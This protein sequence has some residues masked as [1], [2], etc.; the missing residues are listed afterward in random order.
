MKLNQENIN[1]FSISEE[2]WHAI[3]HGLGLA[4]SIAGLAILVGF[5]SINGSPIVIISSAIYGT[6]LI[7]MYGSSTLYHAITHR[8][9]KGLFQK[10]DHSSIYFLI[11][12]SYTPITLISLEGVWG[13]SLAT[14]VWSTAAFGIYMKF[15][16][17]NRFET[18]SL[19]LYVLMGWSIVVAISPL[20]DSLETGGFYLLIA[21]GLSYTLGV[22]Y[23][24]N[25]HKPFYHAVWHLFVL[26]G[27]IFHFFLTL[28][29]II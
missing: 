2:I 8:P 16:Y 11:A 28:L 24:I 19:V 27:S 7:M 18:L 25:D 13:Y 6:T 5:A 12:G 4:L 3:T 20:K 17:P 10:F 9:I 14:A 26:A 21:G 15:A 23:Y 1:N 22:Y 29:Y